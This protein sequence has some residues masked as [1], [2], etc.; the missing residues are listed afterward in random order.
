MNDR[1]S[2]VVGLCTVGEMLDALH[3]VL[4]LGVALAC[5]ETAVATGVWFRQGMYSPNKYE[6]SADAVNAHFR[7]WIPRLGIRERTAIQRMCDPVGSMM[8]G[9]LMTYCLVTLSPSIAKRAVEGGWIAE[10]ELVQISTDEYR[11]YLLSLLSAFVDAPPDGFTGSIDSWSRGAL[12][13][14]DPELPLDS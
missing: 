5:M 1:T 3:K 11:S 9:V 10:A 7:P 12:T 2:E 4:P 8:N 14:L 13:V 6:S